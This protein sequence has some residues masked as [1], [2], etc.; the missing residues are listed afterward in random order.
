MNKG[1]KKVYVTEIT[2]NMGKMQTKM[3]L[4]TLFEVKEATPEGYTI[5]SYVIDSKID[6]DTTNLTARI[7]AMTST[8]TKNIRKLYATDKDGQI[9]KI[10]NFEESRKQAEEMVDKLLD[11]LQLPDKISRDII[12]N[13]AMAN[14]TEEYLLNSMRMYSTPFALNGKTISTGTEEEFTVKEGFKMKRT[15]TQNE[16]GSIQASSNLN[17][18]N[19]ERAKLIVEMASKIFPNQTEDQMQQITQKI[20]NSGLLKMTA[21]EN[22]IYT[23]GSDGWVDSITSNFVTETM[24]QKSSSYY[25]VRLKK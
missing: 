20:V 10:L 6:T 18:S 14:I 4:E 2:T 5:E 22:T 15:Y 19:D 3:T 25:N 12:K 16:D 24:G 17:M 11:E 13:T 9:I 8:M 7:M 23:L 1:D 21:S